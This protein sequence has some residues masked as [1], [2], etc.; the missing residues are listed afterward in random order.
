MTEFRRV[1]FRSVSQSRYRSLEDYFGIPT[2]VN[3][4][5]V[6]ELAARAYALIWNEWFRDENPQNPINL[7]T[8]AE[9]STASG[10]DDVGL[11]DAGFT[12]IHNLLRRGKRHDYFTSALPWPQKGPGVELHLMA[13]LRLGHLLMVSSLMVLFYLALIIKLVRMRD[14][15]IL[16]MVN[17]V[18][19]VHALKRSKILVF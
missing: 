12:G 1:L 15:S 8:F 6:N 2:G 7:S 4:I 18:K 10:L 9:I 11:G 3:G 19:L 14:Y 13:M 5:K 16:M 17:F